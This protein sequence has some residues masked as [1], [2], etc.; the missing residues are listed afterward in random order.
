MKNMVGFNSFKRLYRYP[1]VKN[2]MEEFYD[3]R[4]SFYQKRKDYLMSRLQ[5]DMEVLQNK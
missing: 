3:I 5:R 2:I 1:S 4:L